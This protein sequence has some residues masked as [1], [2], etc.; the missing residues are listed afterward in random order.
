MRENIHAIHGNY[1]YEDPQW[2]EIDYEKEF[3]VLKELS[4]FSSQKIKSCPPKFPY[5]KKL[6]N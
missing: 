3:I 4:L 2:G 5:A 6:E 1:T